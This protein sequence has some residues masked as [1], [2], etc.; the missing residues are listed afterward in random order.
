M[1]PTPGHYS[2]QENELVRVL[3]GTTTAREIGE[4][5]NR[6]KHSVLVAIKRM[7]LEGLPRGTGT[8]LTAE[9]FVALKSVAPGISSIEFAKQRNLGEAAVRWWARKLHIIFIPKRRWTAENRRVL[10]ECSSVE[11]A[12]TALGRTRRAVLGEAKRLG[13]TLHPPN[14]GRPRDSKRD[15]VHSVRVRQDPRPVVR[16]KVRVEYPAIV[17]CESCGAPVSNWSKH[18]ERMPACRKA[19]AR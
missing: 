10:Q 7:G 18:V 8:K 4:R 15:V 5:M 16:K 19:I 9:D 11:A 13:I 12:M 17:W 3:S 1:S 2:E 6:S 14:S